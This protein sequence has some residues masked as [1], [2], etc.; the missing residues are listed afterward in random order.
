MKGEAAADLLVIGGGAAGFFGAIAAAE[1]ARE[2]GRILIL[3]KTGR[4][5]SKVAI[6]G[7]GR[8][9]VTHG[10]EDPEELIRGYPRGHRELLGPLYRWGS[11]ETIEWFEGRG[12]RLKREADGRIFPVSDDSGSVISVLE[13]EA[14][15]HGI[16]VRTRVDVVELVH[17]EGGLFTARSRDGGQ[18][19]AKRV[20]LAIGGL[21]GSP[22][23]AELKRLGHRLAP[24]TPSLFTFKIRDRRL[25]D[26]AGISVDQAVVEL[27]GLAPPEGRGMEGARTQRGPVLVTH[28]GLSGPAVL[29][30]SAWAARDLA[31]TG[32]QFPLKVNWVGDLTAGEVE[33][34]L[35]GLRREAGRSYV[36][37]HC[38]FPLP[39]RLWQRLVESEGMGQDLTWGQV[40][41]QQYQTLS[42]QLV[43]SRFDVLGKSTNKD[44]FVTAGGVELREVD[45]RTM[46]SR[47]CP[48]LHLAG[49]TLDIDG[50]TG[51]FNLQSAWTTGRIAGE[52]IGK[53]VSAAF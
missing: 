46:E 18:W 4:C 45:F 11:R 25:E 37:N 9:N 20:L 14:R 33:K 48:G 26:L 6:S 36:R 41:R 7:G 3:E 29:K 2:G 47:C 49:E 21:K 39:K 22:L 16:E 34:G 35:E 31:P 12:C 32:Y 17:G 53:K 52:S 28:W 13:R 5:L 38:P 10:L 50:V 43:E 42:Q 30:L 27:E 44:E 51:G 40:S 8:C 24:L 19:E 1:E 23:A 15:K